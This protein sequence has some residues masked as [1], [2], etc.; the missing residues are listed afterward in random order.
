MICIDSQRP[1][2]KDERSPD[3]KVIYVSDIF[4]GHQI[5][6]VELTVRTVSINAME[7]EKRGE[8]VLDRTEQV[9]LKMSPQEA[10]VIRDWLSLQLTQMEGKFGRIRFP[11]QENDPISERDS[12]ASQ[13][14]DDA[15]EEVIDQIEEKS[16]G[17]MF[18]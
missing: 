12:G 8:I 3:Y 17:P 2:F 4:G 1:R 10:T 14:A 18:A 11:G 13:W 7:T 16:T 6:Y 15:N 5:D 9:C